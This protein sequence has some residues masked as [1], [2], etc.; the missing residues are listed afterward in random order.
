MAG[1]PLSGK[2]ILSRVIVYNC[3]DNTVYVKS[4]SIRQYVAEFKGYKS[5]R[6]SYTESLTTFNIA[7]KLT[8]WALFSNANVILDANNLQEKRRFDAYLVVEEYSSP[9]AVVLVEAPNDILGKRLEKAG[10]DKVK[11]YNNMSMV[12]FT[13]V[14][15]NYSTITVDLSKDIIQMLVELKGKLPVKLI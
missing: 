4:D 2:I 7:Q 14:T 13:K 9:V 6:F 15:K 1:Y 11:A 3:P 10:E 5:P 12:H 8:M